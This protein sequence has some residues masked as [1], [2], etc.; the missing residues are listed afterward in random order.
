MTWS[1][2]C[3]LIKKYIQHGSC[4][5]SFY[6]GK[7]EDCS[8]GDSTSDSFEK[9]L[10]RGRG[11]SQYTCDFGER[12]IHTIKCMFFQKVSTSLMKHLLVIRNGRHHEGFQCFS[13]YKEM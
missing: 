3:H 8:L 13:R 2:R 6:L 11:E 7:N 12:G 5:L 10:Q 9:L 4:E 1:P